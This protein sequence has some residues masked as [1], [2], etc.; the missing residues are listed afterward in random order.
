MQ[1]VIE[2]ML[3]F[4]LTNLSNDSCAIKGTTTTRKSILKFFFLIGIILAWSIFFSSILFTKHFLPVDSTVINKL[5]LKLIS[6]LLEIVIVFYSLI[7]I[8]VAEKQVWLHDGTV[9]CFSKWQIVMAILAVICIFPCPLLFFIGLKLLLKGKISGKSFL[10]ACCFPL[11]YLLNWIFVEVCRT[12]K[13]KQLLILWVSD[14]ES[15][16]YDRLTGGFRESNEGTQH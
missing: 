2:F 1:S 7:C 6:G 4:K 11:P 5:R 10:V 14:I 8:T 16:I 9:E 12:G 3:D 13:N 15:T